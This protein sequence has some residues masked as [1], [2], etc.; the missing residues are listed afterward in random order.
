[1]MNL[2]KL[3]LAMG[4][5]AAVT[6]GNTW[7]DVVPV[8]D[9][10]AIEKAIANGVLLSKQLSEIQSN[11]QVAKSQLSAMTGNRNMGGLLSDSPRNGLPDDWDSAMGM[12]NSNSGPT[13][14][15]LANSAQQIRQS[16]SVLSSSEA[17]SLSPQMQSY[18]EQMRN[19]SAN[20]QAL[21]QQAYNNSATRVQTLQRLSNSI[22]SST[23]PKAIMDLQA[24]AQ[25][26][27]AKLAN[28]QAQLQSVLQLTQANEAAVRQMQSEMRMQVS[29]QAEFPALDT[30]ITK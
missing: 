17:A 30:S 4:L 20:Q 5:V 29:G 13:Y 27:Q 19:M 23:D 16:Q 22:N 21:G 6:T 12:L 2:K 18:L 8:I 11:L 14:G 9:G 25:S 24:V 10:I 26:E 28:D 3:T 7:A 15:D 1:M